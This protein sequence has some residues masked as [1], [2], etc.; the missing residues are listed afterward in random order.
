MLGHPLHQPAPGFLF[1]GA[2]G[3]VDGDRQIGDFRLDLLA[4]QHVQPADQYGEFQHGRL[5]AVE[6]GERRMRLLADHAAEVAR[7]HAVV[8]TL[9]TLRT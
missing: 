8:G 2:G 6:A 3:L 5:G 4:R 7:P 1:L 9:S